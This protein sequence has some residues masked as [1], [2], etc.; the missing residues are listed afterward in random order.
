MPKPIYIVALFSSIDLFFRRLMGYGFKPSDQFQ[1]L[2]TIL[3]VSSTVATWEDGGT[4]Q[5]VGSGRDNDRM[6]HGN[7]IVEY[8]WSIDG[9]FEPE[10]E[11]EM[12]KEVEKL[13]ADK[14]EIE[15]EVLDNEGNW[16]QAA[17]VEIT[18]A[19]T[20]DDLEPKTIYLPLV[21]K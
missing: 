21:F 16:S 2:A 18:I 6:G 17:S 13:S 3:Y 8:R 1:T 9:E 12:E 5:F 7:G 20:W 11:K 19:E 10:R 4:I 14:H 15:L